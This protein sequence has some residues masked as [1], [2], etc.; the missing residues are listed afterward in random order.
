MSEKLKPC[1]FCGKA[2]R[3]FSSSTLNAFVVDHKTLN[4]CAFYE[5]H[6]PWEIGEHLEH[7]AELWNRR[8]ES[9]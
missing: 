6:I 3:M 5:F 4:H 7:A 1:P 2:V 9:R 8:S